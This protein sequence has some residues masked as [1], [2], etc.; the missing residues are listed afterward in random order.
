MAVSSEMYNVSALST[1]S[2]LIVIRGLSQ[3]AVVG[4]DLQGAEGIWSCAAAARSLCHVCVCVGSEM[5]EE[6]VQTHSL[7]CGSLWVFGE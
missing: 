5:V 2:Q 3:T 7:S 1:T 6:N 4:R